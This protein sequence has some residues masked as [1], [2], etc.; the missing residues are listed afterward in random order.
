MPPVRRFTEAVRGPTAV[1]QDRHRAMLCL[2]Q[3]A[4]SPAN[5]CVH[6]DPVPS[7]VRVVSANVRVWVKPGSIEVVG[8]NVQR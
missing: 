1:V 4:R 6:D 5:L 8:H 2:E 3:F 7:N